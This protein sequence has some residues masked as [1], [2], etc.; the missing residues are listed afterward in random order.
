[1]I[2]SEPLARLRCV[3]SRNGTV[4]TAS[5]GDLPPHQR[6]KGFVCVDQHQL[7][8][9]RHFGNAL[10]NLLGK[11]LCDASLSNVSHR[12]SVPLRPFQLNNVRTPPLL[13]QLIE[14]RPIKQSGCILLIDNT[15]PIRMGPTFNKE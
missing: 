5:S 2:Q 10:N 8:M 4:A 7:S 3:R 12:K 11:V 13:K 1:M 14:A 15:F 9:L 6:R